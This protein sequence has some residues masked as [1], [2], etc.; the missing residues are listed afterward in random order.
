MVKSIRARDARNYLF[1]T[2]GK[3]ADGIT[4]AE[5]AP[6]TPKIL[7]SRAPPSESKELAFARTLDAACRR[8]HWYRRARDVGG[9]NFLEL[10]LHTWVIGENQSDNSIL[11]SF[12]PDTQDEDHR[13]I[14]HRTPVY[15]KDRTVAPAWGELYHLKAKP[16]QSRSH[17]TEEQRT[18]ASSFLQSML[19]AYEDGIGK[20]EG[21]LDASG[22]AY[23]FFGG[24]NTFAK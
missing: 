9:Q 2:A 16:F 24:S 14:V 6:R 20:V 12:F 1:F 17:F 4:L 22:H 3:M 15:Y 8:R 13:L 10:D 5:L 19:K 23:W 7:R 21:V 18:A 11:P